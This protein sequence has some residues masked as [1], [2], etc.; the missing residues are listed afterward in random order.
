LD[1]VWAVQPGTQRVDDG[2]VQTGKPLVDDDCAKKAIAE[3]TR[4]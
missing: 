3:L 1:E 4:E 2:Q